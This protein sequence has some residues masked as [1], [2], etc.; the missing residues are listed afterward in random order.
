MTQEINIPTR[1]WDVINMDFITRLPRV[2][3]HHDSICV[4]VDR[5]TKSSR[6]LAVKTTYS[7]EDYAKL[8]L[9]EIVRLHGVLLSIIKYKGPLF[10]SNFWK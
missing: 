6:F 10:T 2:C 1:K 9:T 5:I 4:I 8:Y 3:G 7:T